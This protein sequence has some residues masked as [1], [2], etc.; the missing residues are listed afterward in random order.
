MR[1]GFRPNC[2]VTEDRRARL[3]AVGVNTLQAIRPNSRS[4]LS[5]RTLAGGSAGS[6]DWKYLSARRLALFI[7]NSIERGTR[8]VV[9][10]PLDADIAG[11]VHN[12]ITEFFESLNDEGA[13]IG[14]AE[15]DGYFVICDERV[16]PQHGLASR[17]FNILF[18]FAALRPGEFHSYLITHSVSG[19]RLKPA[20]L[21]RMNSSHYHPAEEESLNATQRE[22]VDRLADRFNA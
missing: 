20:S 1:P 19:T 17:E 9:F 13:F 18:G 15:G 6:A 22:W 7:I 11:Q 12:Q 2:L 14:R 4:A 5:P 3:A 8:W 21:N 16:N 10:T